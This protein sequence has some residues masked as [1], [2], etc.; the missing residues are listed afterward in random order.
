VEAKMILHK[1]LYQRHGL[2]KG[3]YLSLKVIVF[4][5]IRSILGLEERMTIDYPDK[6]YEY[7]QNL[8]GLPFL[9]VKKDG[10]LRCDACMLCVSYCPSKCIH[11]EAAPAENETSKPVSFHIEALRCIFCG[12]CVEACPID[13]IRMSGEHELAGHAEENWLFDQSKLAY[14]PTLNQGKGVLSTIEVD[15]RLKLEP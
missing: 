6:K 1:Q 13:A 12:F 15:R 14:R 10:E 7:G 11:I 5:S 4:R 3:I 8:K 2:L 9:T